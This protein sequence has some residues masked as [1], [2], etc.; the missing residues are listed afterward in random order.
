M[1]E[2]PLVWRKAGEPGYVVGSHN[3]QGYKY[4][5]DLFYGAKTNE[6]LLGWVRRIFG[7]GFAIH[8]SWRLQEDLDLQILGHTRTLVEAKD[9]LQGYT[10]AWWLTPEAAYWRTQL[11]KD[12]EIYEKRMQQVSRQYRAARQT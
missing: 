12:L 7:K 11:P 3:A 2:L 8:L 9:W 5:T 10:Y 4:D 1:S 6:L